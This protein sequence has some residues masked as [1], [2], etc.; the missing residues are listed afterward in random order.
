MTGGDYLDETHRDCVDCLLWLRR[1]FAFAHRRA[2]Q[3]DVRDLPRRR[4]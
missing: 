4:V 2:Q 3:F 1:M